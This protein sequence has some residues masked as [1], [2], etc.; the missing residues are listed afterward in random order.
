MKEGTIYQGGLFL[1]DIHFPPDYPFKPPKIR[2]LTKVYHPNINSRGTISL[3]MLRDQ[4]SPAYT[5][6]KGE[7][8]SSMGK[9]V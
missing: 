5:I 9:V 4:W 8:Y 6:S 1:L 7:L 2:F 3:E